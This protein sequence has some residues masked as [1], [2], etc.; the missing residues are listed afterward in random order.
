M[1]RQY[2]LEVRLGK[3][4]TDLPKVP[5]IARRIRTWSADWPAG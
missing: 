2:P 4:N 3:R 1:N 5:R